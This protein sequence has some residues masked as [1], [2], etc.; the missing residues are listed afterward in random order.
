MQ[1]CMALVED[2]LG[3][4]ALL[5]GYDRNRDPFDLDG[6]E[7]L[8]GGALR[9]GTLYVAEAGSL[10]ETFTAD[11]SS[12]LLCAGTPPRDFPG[13]LLAV[14]LPL[15][16]LI[17]AV[18][19]VFLRF[20]RLEKQLLEAATVA[21]SM[22]A[23]VDVMQ[24][25]FPH[26]LSICTLDFRVIGRARGPDHLLRDSGLPQPDEAGQLPPEVVSFFKNEL[27][28]SRI[29]NLREPFFYEPSIYTYR[30]HCMN[31]FYEGEPVCR[32]THPNPEGE[33]R[34][35]D[36]GL[37]R[38]FA[39]YVQ[40]VYESAGG[41]R[42]YDPGDSLR[43]TL[44]ELIRGRSFSPE[45]L[46]QAL[47]KRG[48]PGNGPFLCVCLCPSDR[49]IYNHTMPYYC[50]TIAAMSDSL[51]VF[52]YED[53]IVFVVDLN[54]HGGTVASFLAWN[55][56]YMRDNF[57]LLGVS[58]VFRDMGQLR[59][60]WQQAR[61]ALRVG[62]E[63]EPTLWRHRFS[64]LATTYMLSRIP[65]EL[66]AEHL[67]SHQLLL[68]RE[69][70]RKNGTDYFATLKKYLETGMNAVETARQLYIHR[71]TMMYRLSRIREISGVELENAAARLYLL[72]SYAL[73]DDCA[74]E[75]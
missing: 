21:H 55:V 3:G 60:Y 46:E 56:E 36:A 12:A 9:S 4:K 8:D 31:V 72:L 74:A 43:D 2:Q 54:R 63:K 58:D 1:L 35:Y 49:D 61:I 68:L 65:G 24:P 13:R 32:I 30:V 51:C 22:Q 57:F 33:P 25:F 27:Q 73:L 15:P 26:D 11:G 59:S 66:D 14:D 23:L 38:F 47:A 67:C 71:A 50:R 45:A 39:Q 19:R 48:W 64:E 41:D 52:E 44:A 16:A 6:W 70:D 37:I 29:R 75:E 10:P 28:F 18:N 42:D 40:L 69:Y 34:S 62:R 7:L 5:S 17:N 20:Q 53:H